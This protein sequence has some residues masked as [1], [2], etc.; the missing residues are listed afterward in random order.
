MNYPRPK[1]HWIWGLVLASLFPAGWLIAD[2]PMPGR[3][4]TAVTASR[5]EAEARGQATYQASCAGCHGQRGE[6][7]LDW[8]RRR[9]DGTYPAPP[10]DRTGHTWHHADGLLFGIVKEG[11]SFAA[12]PGYLATMPAWQ[13]TLSD[14]QII[15]VLAY[16]RTMWGSEEREFQA[17][18]SAQNPFAVSGQ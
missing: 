16:I 13:G 10:H 11:G 4:T 18:A 17:K 7:Q 1:R 14:A 2:M 15:D 12:P 5:S 6:G 8:K 3:S 9:T